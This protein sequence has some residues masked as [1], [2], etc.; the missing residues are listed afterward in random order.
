MPPIVYSEIVVSG[1]YLGS[2]TSRGNVFSRIDGA[3]SAPLYGVEGGFIGLGN[4]GFEQALFLRYTLAI[5]KGATIRRARFVAT[6]VFQ[7]TA[8]S[9]FF[10]VGVLRFDGRWNADGEWGFREAV[11]GYPDSSFMPRPTEQASDAIL[12]GRLVDDVFLGTVNYKV[13]EVFS[14]VPFGIGD[15]AYAPLYQLPLAAAVQAWIDSADYTPSPRTGEDI[16]LGQIAFVF[17]PYL[18]GAPPESLILFAEESTTAFDGVRLEVE[19][20]FAPLEGQVVARAELFETVSGRAAL[21]ETV[22][23]AAGLLEIVSAR[24]ALI[25]DTAPGITQP[26]LLVLGEV[27]IIGIFDPSIEYDPSPAKREL[28]LTYTS[29]TTTAPPSAERLSTH[30]AKSTDAGATWTFRATV[31]PSTADDL[32]LLQG[33]PVPGFWHYETSTMLR[34]ASDPD[35]ERRWKVLAFRIFWRAFDGTRLPP[36]SWLSLKT[37]PEPEGPWSTEELHI[38]SGNVP[39]PYNI[40]THKF[41]VLDRVLERHI[42]FGEPALLERAGIVYLLCTG[43]RATGSTGLYLFRSLDHLASWQF[44]RQ[45]TTVLDYR[46]IGTLVCDGSELFEIGTRTFLLLAW[47]DP[48]SLLYAGTKLFEFE[49]FEAGVLRRDS[50]GALLVLDSRPTLPQ[51]NS[52][53]HGGGQAGYHPQATACGVLQ[54]QIAFVDSQLPRWARI[55]ATRWNP[56]GD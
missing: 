49:D 46:G 8:P 35:T 17:D 3:T 10:R 2:G 39:D 18:V 33:G 30:L 55:H 34:D 37:A 53:S 41:D 4:S 44:V 6:P 24:A 51:I 7:P 32:I 16:S 26:D 14:A 13:G 11:T 21:F 36:Y 42:T 31:F 15:A 19:W 54:S 50:L 25:E 47:R 52:G 40:Q 20:E 9:G 56:I 23:V 45:V 28:W 29:A 38:G 43:L 22:S 27:G 48:Y 1:L 12:A 5:P